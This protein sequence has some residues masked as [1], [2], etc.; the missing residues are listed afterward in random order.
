MTDRDQDLLQRFADSQ[1]EGAFTVLVER[2]QALVVSVCRRVLGNSHD[3]EDVAQSVFFILAKKAGSIAAPRSLAPWLHRVATDMAR[4]AWNAR[5]AR[6]HHQQQAAAMPRPATAPDMSEELDAALCQLPERERSAIVLFH[7]E[8]QSLEEIA[9][10]IQRPVA[11]VGY[12]LQRGRERLRKL[13]GRRGVALSGTVLLSGLGSL[14]A[15]DLPAGFALATTK[16][17]VAFA[18]TGIATTPAAMLAA[19]GCHAMKLVALIKSTV[20][21]AAITIA[22]G[23]AGLA[24]AAE[25][26]GKPKANVAMGSADFMPTPERPLGY[27]GDWTGLFT[28]ATPPLTWSRRFTGS[29]VS[30]A[31]Y[32]AKKPKGDVAPKDA[33]ALDS[34]R[35]IADLD[36]VLGT[37]LEE[38]LD[39]RTGMFR[40]LPFI[41]VRE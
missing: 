27:R 31:M 36:V 30:N 11:T 1:D 37:L 34:G 17:A 6:E 41:A 8:G 39:A 2:H 20:L 21:A 25:V 7:L 32:Q 38:A 18:A 3:A 12:W 5:R 23:G 16:G 19:K 28:G 35:N 40:P 29:A 24:V 22:I 4:N 14:S 26:G 9:S 33:Q 10:A 13:L 15:A